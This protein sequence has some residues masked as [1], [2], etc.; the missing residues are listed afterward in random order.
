MEKVVAPESIATAFG[1]GLADSTM[2]SKRDSDGLFPTTLGGVSVSVNSRAAQIFYVSPNQ[3]NFQIPADTE[4]GM[5]DVII[6]NG[7]GV[8][9]HTQV[10]VA[11]TAPGIFTENGSGQGNAVVFDLD[12][13]IGK[14]VLATDD[15]LRRFYVYATG[16]RGA[17]SLQVT[18][19]GHPVTVE[20]IK[21]CRGLSGL[22]QV[23]IVFS[24]DL[25]QSGVN[26]L[27][28]TADG[29]SSNTTILGL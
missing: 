19:N 24:D 2:Q 12:R 10:R 17:A 3:V 4:I 23:T 6:T 15:N 5:A 1:L 20:R 29:I 26:L 13:L 16:V 27:Q 8:Q 25:T 7:D 21:A 14:E 9:M 28:I 22:D 18:I 11:D